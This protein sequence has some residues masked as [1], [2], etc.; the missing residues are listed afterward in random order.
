MGVSVH[1]F[2]LS[3]AHDCCSLWRGENKVIGDY[4]PSTHSKLPDVFCLPCVT[5]D[6]LC[7]E[8]LLSMCVKVCHERLVCSNVWGVG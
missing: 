7:T 8:C 5:L 6:K 1:V 4:L 2:Y 3:S